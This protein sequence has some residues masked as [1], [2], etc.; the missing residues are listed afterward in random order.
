[1]QA[2]SMSAALGG[3]SMGAAYANNAP[4]QSGAGLYVQVDCSNCIVEGLT[5]ATLTR[6]EAKI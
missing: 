4:E 3:C 1:M 6:D 2:T 5:Q